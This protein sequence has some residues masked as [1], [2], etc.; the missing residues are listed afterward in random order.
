MVKV[1]TLPTCPDILIQ[2]E[3]TTNGLKH[4]FVFMGQFLISFCPM[5]NGTWRP[6]LCALQGLEHMSHAARPVMS[7]GM[8]KQCKILAK[9]G[10]GTYVHAH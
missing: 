3:L 6:K 4:L 10:P 2:A 9:K 1:P 5:N 8:I 7:N